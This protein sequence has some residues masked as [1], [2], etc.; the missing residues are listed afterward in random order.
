MKSNI[1]GISQTTNSLDVFLG[2]GGWN[3]CREHRVNKIPPLQGG[4][5]KSPRTARFECSKRSL[6]RNLS[7]FCPE[8]VF[9][10]E[11]GV[12][13]DHPWGDKAG[14]LISFSLERGVGVCVCAD[15]VL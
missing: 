10:C 7:V 5:Y 3:I 8:E 2:G 15:D 11:P 1:L 9:E 6:R 4:V 14:T 12:S 13:L